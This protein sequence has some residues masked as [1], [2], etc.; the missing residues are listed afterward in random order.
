MS[1]VHKESDIT[2]RIGLDSNNVPVRIQW[3]AD[4]SPDTPTFRPS[5]AMLLSFFDSEFKDTYKIDLWTSDL[6]VA[7]M[8]KL[9]YQ[10]LRGLADSYHRATNNAE[11]AN[12]MQKF[13][14]YFG[15]KTGLIAEK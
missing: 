13:V 9:M 1:K 6:E 14:Q 12:D 8:D 3:K 15:E 2:C 4:S 5:K 11:L 10:T 7:E